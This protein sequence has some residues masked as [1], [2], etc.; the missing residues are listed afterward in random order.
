MDIRPCGRVAA[1]VVPIPTRFAA[2]ARGGGAAGAIG[3]AAGADDG[4]GAGMIC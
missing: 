3:F 2:V 4:V 1:L